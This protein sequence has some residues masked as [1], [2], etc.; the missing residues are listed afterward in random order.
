MEMGETQRTCMN[1]VKRDE[2]IMKKATSAFT[3]RRA[4]AQDAVAIARLAVELGYPTTP[5]T[6]RERI[7]AVSASPADLLLVA[8]DS[9]GEPIAWLQAHSAQLIESGFR[10]EIVGL[11]VSN[12]VRR[13]G[14]G[15]SLVAETERWAMS[16]RAQI[17]VV[18][19]NAKR[20]ESHAFY[21]ALGFVKT[22]TQHVYRKTLPGNATR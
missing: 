11:I 9:S 15:R 12:T 21:P 20:I 16:L 13:S 22:K 3:L 4:T 10:V 18:R 6:M 5:D 17:L 8:A 1:N 14:V 2:F 19:S 7:S